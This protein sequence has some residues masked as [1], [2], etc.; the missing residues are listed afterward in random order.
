M[1][2]NFQVK[3]DGTRTRTYSY[4]NMGFDNA[5]MWAHYLLECGVTNIRIIEHKPN[6][7]TKEEAV[8]DYL[9]Y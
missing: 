8:T 9:F 5:A 4:R 1:K 2:A 6:G 7:E 3:A